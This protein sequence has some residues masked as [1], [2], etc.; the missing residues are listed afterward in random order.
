MAE[1]TLL[2]HVILSIIKDHERRNRRPP[3]RARLAVAIGLSAG[4]SVTSYLDAL[5]AEGLIVIGRGW[6]NIGT[7]SVRRPMPRRGLSADPRAAG[8]RERRERLAKM[9]KRAG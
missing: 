2:H 1:L 6:Q 9:A 7:A 3:T 5:A 4:T 8:R